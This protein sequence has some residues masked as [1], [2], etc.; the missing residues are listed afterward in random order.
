MMRNLL[1]QRRKTRK[2]R[3]IK[4]VKNKKNQ[5]VHIVSEIIFSKYFDPNFS[6][7]YSIN[8]K[9]NT[10]KALQAIKHFFS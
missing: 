9:F 2:I 5:K 10:Y 7:S 1:I 6:N 4:R 3:R 8:L